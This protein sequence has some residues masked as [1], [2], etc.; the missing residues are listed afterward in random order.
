MAHFAR[1]QDGKVIDV[2]VVVN[3]VIADHEGVEQ[4]N[5]GQAFLANL[6]GGDPLEYVQC[7]YN[8]TMRGCYPGVG[9]TWDGTVFAPPPQP[10]PTPE[11][12]ALAP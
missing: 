4:E 1:I 3:A 9:Y 6:W 2:H 5:I 7:S 10:E 8:A 11:P 12:D